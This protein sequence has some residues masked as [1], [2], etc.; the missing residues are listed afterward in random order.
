MGGPAWARV[1]GS[2]VAMAIIGAHMLLYSSDVDGLRT[3]LR[4]AFGLRSVDAGPLEDL[5]RQLRRSVS[6]ATHSS[7]VECRIE[8]MG[9]RP[10]GTTPASATI[11]QAA[12]EVTRRFGI[13]PQPDVGSTDANVPISM[14]I[15]A[16]AIG[17]GGT[18]GNVH[19]PEEW[20]DPAN[21][22]L[23]I[24]RLLTLIGVLAGLA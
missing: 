10:S 2:I 6:E 17:G 15:P 5:E 1:P 14:G 13:E 9:E 18:A 7:G 20:F 4:D 16:L 24:Q 3:Q 12:F 21:R 11:V 8:L 22:Y 19:T 23:G